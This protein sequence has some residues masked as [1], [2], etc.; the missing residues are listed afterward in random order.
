MTYRPSAPLT[1]WVAAFTAAAGA[2]RFA[3]DARLPGMVTNGLERSTTAEANDAVD[4]AATLYVLS[5]R[6][7]ALRGVLLSGN[8]SAQ[9]RVAV[10][11][12]LADVV[13]GLSY[14]IG[15]MRTH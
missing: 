4:A 8:V 10:A 6:L 2:Q 1:D 11:D 5:D 9:K 15:Q 12:A 13:E 14:I 7:D 3:A